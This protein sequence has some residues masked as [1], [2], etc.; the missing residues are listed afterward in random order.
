MLQLVILNFN[1]RKI[2]G[3]SSVRNKLHLTT[4]FIMAVDK[5]KVISILK[6]H[7]IIFSVKY[8]IAKIFC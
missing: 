4:F 3:I 8:I 6:L 1:D 2:L 5:T 7:I